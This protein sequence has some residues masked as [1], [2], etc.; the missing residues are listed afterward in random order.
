MHI[1]GT[2]GHVDHGKSSLVEALTGTNPD[3]LFEEQLRG[4]TLDLGF[5]YLHLDGGSEAGIVDVPGHERFLHNMLAGAAGMELLLLVVAAN[6]GVMAQTVEH[7]QILRFLNVARTIVVVTKADLLDGAELDRAVAAIERDLRGTIAAGAPLVRVSSR[8]GYGLE[9]LRAAIAD[10]LNVLPPRALDAPAYLPIDRVFTLAGLGTI[11][12]GTLMQGTISVGEALVLEPGTTPVRVR[13][14]HVF[15]HSKTRVEGGARVAVNL[16][17]IEKSEIARGAVLAHPQLTPRAEFAV[18]FEAVV[19]AGSLLRRKQR[20]RVYLGSAEILGTLL[21][22]EIPSSGATVHGRL[23]LSA[24]TVA[25]PG[26]HYVVRR[27]SPKTLLGGGVIDAIGE[28]TVAD[29]RSPIGE[30]LLTVL[31]ARGGAPSDRVALAFEA[32]IREDVVAEVLADLVARGDVLALRKPDEYLCAREARTVL[33]RALAV[34]DEHQRS[35]PWSAGVTSIALARVLAVP[36]RVLVR[37]LASY[38]DEGR[39]AARSGYYATPEH[40]PRLSA[41]Q[42][43]FFDSAFP[44]DPLAPNLPES[45][46]RVASA[47]RASDITG[48][49]RAFETLL[50]RGVIVKVDTALYRGAQISAIRHAVENFLR[51]EG[52]MTAAEFRDLLGTSRKYAV[53][54]LEWFDAHGVTV[55][56]GNDRMLRGAKAADAVNDEA[57]SPLRPPV[58]TQSG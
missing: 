10:A 18:S 12:T 3:R 48:I 51:R 8:S 14:L 23:V 58:P 42:R 38:A 49:A 53:P 54:L 24:S 31:R 1:I 2:A 30:R 45:F 40:Q 22:D 7:L 11:V 9:D 15:H 6:E 26:V 25:F 55:R 33:D 17:G 44:L 34:L 21:L 29:D 5:A 13:S 57:A 41:E 47:V 19:E 4:M 39:V 46:D 36:E 50:V 16:P 56:S 52:K 35:E 32:N 20:V 37:I 27:L 43:R 28:E